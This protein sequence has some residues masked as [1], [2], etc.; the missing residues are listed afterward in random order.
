MTA[1]GW[2]RKRTGTAA[3]LAR[4]ALYASPEH[5]AV[6]QALKVEVEAGRGFCWRCGRH[7]PPGSKWHAGHDDYDRS[8]YRGVECPDC[9]LRSAAR[10]GARK[11]NAAQRATRV[12]L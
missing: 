7:I 11:R 2:H 8:V 5:R 6:R 4:A 3:G 12:R 10:K 9:N 1:S